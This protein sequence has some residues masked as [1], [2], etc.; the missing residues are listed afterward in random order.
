MEYINKK[1]GAVATESGQ[2][3]GEAGLH[4]LKRGLTE[5]WRDRHQAAEA[6]QQAGEDVEVALSAYLAIKL[7]GIVFSY[8]TFLQKVLISALY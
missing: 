3:A 4:V 6:G 8:E 5:P 1:K 7:L 2:L